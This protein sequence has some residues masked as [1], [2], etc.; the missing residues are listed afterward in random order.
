MQN[1]YVISYS[2]QYKLSQVNKN[3]FFLCK[4]NNKSFKS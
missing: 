2:G 4:N 1:K 3:A